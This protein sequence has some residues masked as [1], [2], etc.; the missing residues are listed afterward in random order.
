[1][2]RRTNQMIVT[3]RREKTIPAM[4]ADVGV[5]KCARVREAFSDIIRSTTAS[6]HG[7]GF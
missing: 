6:F 4:A 5:F 3:I 1:M 2:D 7:T